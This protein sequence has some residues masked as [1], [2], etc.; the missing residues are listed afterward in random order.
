M[1]IDI[2][3]LFPEMLAGPLQTSLLGKAV[4][5]GLLDVALTNIRDF[6][7]DRHNTV[8]DSPYG[9]GAGM[10]MKCEP[11]YAAVESLRLKNSLERVI[12]L[13]P[14]GAPLTQARVR[15]LAREPDLV[16]LCA[17]YEGVDERVSQDLVTEEISIGD[18]VLSGGELPALVLVEA[19]SR[20]IPGVIGDWE[21]VETDSFYQGILG[22]PQYTRPPVF[23]DMAVPPV[24]R[25]GNHAAIR[26]W[27]R[28]EALRATR[29]RRPDLLIEL[30]AEDKE[31]LAEIEH[32]TP[33]SEREK[34]HEPVG[35]DRPEADESRGGHPEV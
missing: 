12:L 13:S 32:E 17:R 30:T 7:A 16:L 18:Y 35:S 8:D 5:E 34:Y 25:E 33:I 24:L 2:L 22:P 29:D 21:S 26:R 3:T 20:M 10:V 9:G 15:E 6:A 27:R 19:I 23:R 14:R 31:L 1:R 11:I 28:R 4:A